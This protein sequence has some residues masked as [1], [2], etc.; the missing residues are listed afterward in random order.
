MQSVEVG[1]EVG[2]SRMAPDRNQSLQHDFT[3]AS[4]LLRLSLLTTV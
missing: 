2:G 1:V 4:A 3:K